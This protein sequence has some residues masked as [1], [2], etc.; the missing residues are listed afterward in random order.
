MKQTLADALAARGY[1]T[2]T[3]VQEAVSGDDVIGRDLLVSAQ[4]GSGK[5]IGFGIAIA[6]QL[7]G[8]AETFSRA[9]AP[10]ALVI[11]PTRE[12]ALQV[13]RELE[14]LYK[15]AGAVVTSTV[16]GMDIRDERRALE[17]GAH[18][19]VATPGRLRDHVM[20]RTINM[21]AL[22][23]VVLDEADE[24]LRMGFIDDVEW[25]LEQTPK[26]RQ[27]A[28]FSATMP[29]QVRRIATAHLTDPAQITIKMKRKKYTNKNKAKNADGDEQ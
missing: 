11:A 8:D 23:A 3:A 1:D 16:G 9:G 25:I 28:L 29:T 27:I 22:R 17:R 14:W 15:E 5:T 6:P 2:L 10:L 12:L 13:K 7:L 20:R 24:M 26:T 4:T 18:I 21:D 19:V